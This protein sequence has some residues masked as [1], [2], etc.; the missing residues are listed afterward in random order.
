M[1]VTITQIKTFHW[2]NVSLW[3]L[4]NMEPNCHGYLLSY[5]TRC[6]QCSALQWC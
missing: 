6:T 5:M 4:Q 2:F 3:F 1:S